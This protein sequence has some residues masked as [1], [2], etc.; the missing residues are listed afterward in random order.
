M[1]KLIKY[2]RETLD[3]NATCKDW[4]DE[5]ERTLSLQLFGAF[6]YTLATV[7]NEQILFL[8]PQGKYTPAQLKAWSK[9]IEEK[10]GIPA[11]LALEEISPYASHRFIMDRVGFVVPGKQLSLPFLVLR[12]KT[13]KLRKTKEIKKFA[14][15]AQL[16]FL[17]ILYSDQDKFCL[18]TLSEELSISPM[19]ATRAARDLADA[20]LLDVDVAGKTGRKKT[21]KRIPLKSYYSEGLQYL[22]DPVREV[23]YVSQIPHEMDLLKADLTAL[24][25]QTMLGEPEQKCYC[26]PSK[27]RKNFEEYEVTKE[28]ALTEGLPKIQLMKYDTRLLSE[29]GYEDPVSL[30]LGLS[31]KDERIDMAIDELMRGKEWYVE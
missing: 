22:D 15:A 25:E 8:S 7:L 16:V 26:A 28:Q 5:A 24:S 23:I 4:S 6:K 12:I 2:L 14:P 13:E 29:N 10:T 27:M 31:E 17:Y 21:L 1:E 20:G 9:L 11:A 3:A 30:I 18:E 19:T